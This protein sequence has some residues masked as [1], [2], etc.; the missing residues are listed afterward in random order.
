MEENKFRCHFS[1]IFEEIYK[2]L[3]FAVTFF[4]SLL[5]GDDS[6][7]EI[8]GAGDIKFLLYLMAAVA[9]FISLKLKMEENNNYFR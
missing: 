6:L 1:I 9:I 4:I 7:L 3:I 5:I 2:T 8:G